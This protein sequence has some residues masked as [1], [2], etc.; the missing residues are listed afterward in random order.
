MSIKSFGFRKRNAYVLTQNARLCHH[1]EFFTNCFYALIKKN[2]YTQNITLTKILWSNRK[3]TVLYIDHYTCF[4]RNSTFNLMALSMHF[5]HTYSYTLCIMTIR[6]I[7]STL[8]QDTTNI[9]LYMYVVNINYQ[10]S[11]SALST[12]STQ[13]TCDEDSLK[14]KWLAITGKLE[15]L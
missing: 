4:T 15:K 14:F 3:L 5:H 2:V 6:L 8:C 12:L 13:I 11:P 1:V 9:I 7:T 10:N